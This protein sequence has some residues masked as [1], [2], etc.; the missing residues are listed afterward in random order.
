MFRIL[1]ISPFSATF[2]LL[3]LLF[4]TEPYNI[5]LYAYHNKNH[6]PAC[7]V[8]GKARGLASLRSHRT[9]RSQ[10]LPLL[11]VCQGGSFSNPF[12]R[13]SRSHFRPK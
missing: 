3:E 12:L 5:T 8:V 10:K 7:K 13:G 2:P 4:P 1:I 11:K 6:Y 9:L